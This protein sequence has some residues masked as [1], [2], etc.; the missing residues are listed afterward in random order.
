MTASLNVRMVAKKELFKIPFFGRILKTYHFISI[1]RSCKKNAISS[2]KRSLDLLKKGVS[3]LFFP[4]GTRYTKSQGKP[5]SYNHLLTP[6]TIG[7]EKVLHSM[8]DKIKVIDVTL[9]YYTSNLS[10]LGFLRG[11][12]GRVDVHS[13][14]ETVH[15]ENAEQWL[16]ERWA[17][18]DQ[19]LK[20]VP[21]GM[22]DTD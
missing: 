10:V 5:K 3:V 6:R 12:T 20:S 17:I 9:Q 18:K 13:H 16:L 14:C 7:F 11:E 21:H 2:L 4:E 15:H 8:G 1:D 19:L 22:S